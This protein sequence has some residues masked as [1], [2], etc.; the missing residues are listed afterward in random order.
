M[1][2]MVEPAL[3]LGLGLVIGFVVLAM[4]MPIF[5]MNLTVR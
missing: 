2:T 3:I 1:T 4:L 5:Q